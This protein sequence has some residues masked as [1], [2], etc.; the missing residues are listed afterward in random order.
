ME[1]KDN[2]P[3]LIGKSKVV[4]CCYDEILLRISRKSVGPKF[5]KKTKF[6]MLLNR[7]DIRHRS[8]SRV[9]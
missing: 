6:E 4:E 3:S 8:S 1:G 5:I 7:T 2:R 9:G